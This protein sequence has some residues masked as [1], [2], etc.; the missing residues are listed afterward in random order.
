M[1]TAISGKFDLNEAFWQKMEKIN[2]RKSKMI[3]GKIRVSE[4]KGVKD[5]EK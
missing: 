5:E 1:G 4:F 3:N 2:Q